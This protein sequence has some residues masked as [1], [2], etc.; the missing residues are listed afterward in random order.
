[1]QQWNGDDLKNAL[2]RYDKKRIR[3]MAK[4]YA[5]RESFPAFVH[6]LLMPYLEE[7]G[8]MW[9]QG[10]VS[11]SQLYLCG[12]IS[13]A[14]FD[15]YLGDTQ[16]MESGGNRIAI[17]TLEDYHTLGKHMVGALVRSN[18]YNLLDFGA[19]V[20][21]R[22]AAELCVTHGV[23]ILMVS[24]LMYPSARKVENLKNELVNH[25]M[26]TRL[27]VGGA[28]FNMD[29]SLWSAVGADAM[30]NTAYAGVT[31]LGEWVKEEN[32]Q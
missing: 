23:D 20:G 27:M 15:E 4:D 21:Y 5:E 13:E 29:A 6:D 28:P 31:L 1:M 2:L 14:L 26:K 9:T 3:D 12:K 16:K 24:V 30:G 19:G 11:L 7:I 8:D 17:V 25:G 18:G 10:S 32:R 22:Y